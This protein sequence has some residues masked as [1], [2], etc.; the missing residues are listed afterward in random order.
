MKRLLTYFLTLFFVLI[1]ITACGGMD[2]DDEPEITQLSGILTKQSNE[3]DLPGTHI[4][5]DE[6]GEIMPVRSISIN[7]SDRKYLDNKVRLF[8][9]MNTEE[10]VFSVTGVSVLEILSDAPPVAEITQYKN[11]DYGFQIDYYEDW[12]VSEV[13]NLVTFESPETMDKVYIDQFPFEYSQSVFDSENKDNPLYNYA[14]INFP[15]LG[16]VSDSLLK[17]GIDKSEA[18]KIENENDSIDYYLYRNGLIYRI[19][20]SP[21]NTLDDLN[22]SKN[23]FNEMLAGFRFIGFTVDDEMI[24]SEFVEE[25][26]EVIDSGQSV[27]DSS[28][29]EGDE[30]FTYFDSLPYSFRA[31]YPSNWYYAGT[32]SSD[33]DVLHHYGFADEPVE[34]SNELYG[35]DVYSGVIPNGQKVFV[36]NNEITKVSSGGKLHLYVS[37]DNHNFKIS[38]DGSIEDYMLVT[39]G[40]IEKIE[41]ND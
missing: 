12:E 17:I 5:T 8:G 33:S 37:L 10:E 38:G 39:A 19:T 35:L 14:A 3:N 13:D 23:I 30:N 26:S 2:I 28:S 6:N 4:I 41:V 40:S 21:D 22:E 11:S 34:N 7:L 29:L 27:L 18:L 32:S 15:Q 31:K 9:V 20:F 16:D 24:D 25:S 1:G 36:G